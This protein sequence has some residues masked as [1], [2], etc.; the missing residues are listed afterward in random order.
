MGTS[1]G[2]LKTRAGTGQ[3]VGRSN[4]LIALM[5]ALIVGG[6]LVPSITHDLRKL[7]RI[8]SHTD[9]ESHPRSQTHWLWTFLSLGSQVVKWV[10]QVITWYERFGDENRYPSIKRLP[11]DGNY[12]D[13]RE[14]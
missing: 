4:F 3:G 10:Q 1:Q 14:V 7:G 13:Y 8:V 9:Q 12:F 5:M 11:T 2:T 6:S